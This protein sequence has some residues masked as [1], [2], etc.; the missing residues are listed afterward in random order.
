MNVR[1]LE[2]LLNDP[3]SGVTAPA[4]MILEPIQGE[5]GVIAA[6]DRWLQELRRL[7]QAHGIPLI[8]DE[9]QCGIARSGR[10][11]GF[12]QSGITPDVITLSKAIGG[13]LPL[14]V[15]VYHESLDVW[16]PGA[17]AGT[18]RGN[19]LAM[20][21]GTATLRFIRDQGLVQHA[22]TVGVHLQKQLQA[23]QNEFA[24]IGDV[25]GRGLMLGMEIVDPQGTPDVQ[26]HP[27]VDTARAKAFQQA[28]LK[29]GLIVELGGR[30]GATVRFLPPLIITEQEIDFVAKILFQAASTIN[31]RP[32][33]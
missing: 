25:R 4:A 6:P 15:M 27:P 33:G 10:M 1:Y 31:E 26:G 19:Q 12:E 20:A 32:A 24:W 23:L 2:H 5:G 30:H 16:Q 7:T 29:H 9:I 8:V 11:F 21:A 17:H 14:S 13:G 22:E 28:C 3:E 18:F